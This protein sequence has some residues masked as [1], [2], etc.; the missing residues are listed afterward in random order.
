MLWTVAFAAALGA[1][2]LPSSAAVTGTAT[3]VTGT[4]TPVNATLPVVALG[5]WRVLALG[6]GLFLA[7]PTPGGEDPAF[8]YGYDGGSHKNALKLV[9]FHGGSDKTAAVET[10]AKSPGLTSADLQK[11][12]SFMAELG[13]AGD[14]KAGSWKEM[15]TDAALDLAANSDVGI[16]AGLIASSL[17]ASTNYTGANASVSVGY[18]KA[19]TLIDSAA[20]SVVSEASL[21]ASAEATS[22][23]ATPASTQLFA[24]TAAEVCADVFPNYPPT[25][26][27]AFPVYPPPATPPPG[28]TPPSGPGSP[29][30]VGGSC[31]NFGQTAQCVNRNGEL[32]NCM[33]DGAGSTGI[34]RSTGGCTGIPSTTPGTTGPPA[35]PGS[36]CA[37]PG[38]VGPCG[39][40]CA[41]NCTATPGAPPGSPGTW[42]PTIG[43]AGF[44]EAGYGLILLTG[45]LGLF[46][47]KRSRK[48][49]P[50]A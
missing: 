38:G 8:V 21:T 14:G 41:C 15:T 20:S 9:A 2:A 33:C 24:Q 11:L 37:P 25:A 34:W 23:I 4:A 31:T 10:L 39:N 46:L 45:M 6:G 22:E 36:P 1:A 30:W 35:V 12:K 48:G 17:S 44:E 19:A 3:P 29:V 43:C 18:C 32:C 47:A 13:W 27:P 28:W 49:T 7:R 16:F 40:Q 26:P 50:A 5:E 42:S